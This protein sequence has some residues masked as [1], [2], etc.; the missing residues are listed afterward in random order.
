MP[1]GLTSLRHHWYCHPLI[2][3]PII[4]PSII[5]SNS[6][7]PPALVCDLTSLQYHLPSAFQFIAIRIISRY[8]GSSGCVPVSA[9]VSA[10][11]RLS[12]LLSVFVIYSIW[13]LYVPHYGVWLYNHVLPKIGAKL[14]LESRL[15]VRVS[16]FL[17]YL[18]CRAVLLL[19]K[20]I[21]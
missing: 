1:N 12:A 11:F 14:E 19:L 20:D 3:P 10:L 17:L 16:F 5:G 9:S 6:Y 18:R 13:S 2:P 21:L 15:C 8:N 7:H 4:S